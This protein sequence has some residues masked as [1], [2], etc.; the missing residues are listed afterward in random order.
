MAADAIRTPSGESEKFLLMPLP[1]Q[2]MAA[3]GQQETNN[4]AELHNDLGRFRDSLLL[5]EEKRR[6]TPG[7]EQL[8]RDRA[9]AYYQP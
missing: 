5:E 1:R 3:I 2:A 6:P 8:L 4:S 7:L 9:I